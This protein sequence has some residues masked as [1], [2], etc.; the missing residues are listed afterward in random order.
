MNCDNLP[1]IRHLVRDK[2]KTAAQVYGITCSRIV[3]LALLREFLFT[4]K[5]TRNEGKKKLLGHH[6][7]KKFYRVYQYWKK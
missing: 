3:I 7:L 1:K 6:D 4:L 2:M 5:I